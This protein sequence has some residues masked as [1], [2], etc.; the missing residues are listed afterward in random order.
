MARVAPSRLLVLVFLVSLLVF[1]FGYMPGY[2]PSAQAHDIRYCGHDI[3][4]D[5]NWEPGEY[6]DQFI[7]SHNIRWSNTHMHR[8]KHL[9]FDGVSYYNTGS[10]THPCGPAYTG[11]FAECPYT[12]IPSFA[13]PE[14]IP[15]DCF[16]IGPPF[17]G[18]C[19]IG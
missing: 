1:S 5:N 12:A 7:R 14:G 10:D 4:G 15:D 13:H 18:T 6:R 11:C 3:S 8:V 17:P 2:T 16:S 19:E 9:Y